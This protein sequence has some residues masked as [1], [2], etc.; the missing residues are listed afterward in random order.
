MELELVCL[1]GYDFGNG[2]PKSVFALFL[3]GVPLVDANAYLF[4]KSKKSSVHSIRSR[5][6]QL[7][8]F[9]SQVLTDF[10]D[11]SFLGD[12]RT[13]P[14]ANRYVVA[15]QSYL[16]VSDQYMSAY[17][18]TLSRGSSAFTK[19]K[20]KASSIGQHIETIRGFYSFCYKYGFSSKK[21]SF[22]YLYDTLEQAETATIG[23]NKKIYELYYNK[24]TFLA[25]I[26]QIQTK[27]PF[28]KARNLLILKLCYF[29]GTRPHELIKD[30]HNFNIKKLKEIIK[31]DVPFNKSAEL[32]ISGKGRGI[33]KIRKILIPPEV[34]QPLKDYLYI[35][36]PK[37]EKKT[38]KTIK[39]NIFVNVR[40]ERLKKSGNFND[41]I[42]VTAKNAYIAKNN[43]PHHDIKAWNKRN[44][45]STRHCFATNLIIERKKEGKRIDQIV[46]KELMG[47]S[48]FDTTLSSYI[49]LAAVLTGDNEMQSMAID[50][51]DKDKA[52]K[53]EK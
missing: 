50:M 25:L 33:G 44:L 12:D 42:W 16:K 35:E 40:G 52:H 3:E 53:N 36:I 43:L 18:N 45:Y 37:L 47:H 13:N 20:L 11:W 49:Y 22:T 5:A 8:T 6:T 26:G 21:Q 23:L 14:T 27:N 38:G 7:K 48:R 46:I 39:G 51:A 17:L 2:L 29:S 34:Y 19:C 1:D 31:Q 28:L 32:I 4:S 9:L 15:N 41:D 10:N 24:E 30:E